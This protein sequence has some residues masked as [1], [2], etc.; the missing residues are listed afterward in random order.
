M[1]LGQLRTFVEVARA[2]SVGGAAAALFVTE[3][4]VSAAV[5]SL[6]RE[7]GVALV[8]LDGR[9]IRLTPAG[10]ELARYAEQ[11]VGLS[12]QAVR[13]ARE[14]GGGPGHLR[15]VGVTTAGE[16][17]LPP[18]LAEF[19]SRYPQVQVSLEVGNRATVIGRLVAREADLAVGGR[20]PAESQISGEAFLDNPLVIV[21]RA[22]HPLS[23][24]R[25]IAA[26]AIAGETWLLREPGSG[27]RE[28]T[29]EL[30]ARKGIAP[31]SVMTVGSNGA[32]KQAAAVGLG[33]TLM[34]KHAVSAELESGSLAQLRVKG[35][36]LR[37]SWYALHLE[38]A[39]IPRSAQLFL[40]LLRSRAPV[41][42]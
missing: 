8:E 5:A 14:A 13:A 33:V 15:L 42:T 17:V 24:R 12:S 23:A 25:S 29:E 7:I 16:Y 28:T 30:W 31:A 21:A 26:T 40:N 1:T 38:R 4:S 6:R 39:P 34:S 41:A 20:P 37:R 9:G 27:T 36:P 3:P 19:R 32:I 11:I 35:T 2:G 18:L 10:E 22:D